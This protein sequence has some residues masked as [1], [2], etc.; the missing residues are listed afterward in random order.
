MR[1]DY[2]K[3]V[4]ITFSLIGIFFSNMGFFIKN[5]KN[6]DEQKFNISR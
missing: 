2:N 1:G 6:P 3:Q 5:N 4:A